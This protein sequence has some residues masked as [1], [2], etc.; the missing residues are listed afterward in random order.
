[1]A[2]DAADKLL[3]QTGQCILL[4]GLVIACYA[5][6]AHH[7]PAER[8]RYRYLPRRLDDVDGVDLS[9]IAALGRTIA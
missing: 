9:G 5:A 4:L 1:M 2:D 6:G 3:R 7:A 8:I